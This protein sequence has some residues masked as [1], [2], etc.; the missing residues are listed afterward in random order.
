MEAMPNTSVTASDIYMED[1]GFGDGPFRVQVTVTKT[2][3][4]SSSTSR[5]RIRSH[6][7]R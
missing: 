5:A 7:R 1:D 4:G 6:C 3:D 2:P